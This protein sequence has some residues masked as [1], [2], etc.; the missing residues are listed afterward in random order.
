VPCCAVLSGPVGGKPCTRFLLRSPQPSAARVAPRG[1]Q[2]LHTD[3][4]GRARQ[5]AHT[6]SCRIIRGPGIALARWR[7][8]GVSCF[9]H[10]TQGTSCSPSVRSDRAAAN[11]LTAVLY[12]QLSLTGNCFAPPV[13]M[14][15]RVISEDLE[16][17]PTAPV[18]GMGSRPPSR[19]V[20]CQ[21]RT[22][23]RHSI[24]NG[25]TPTQQ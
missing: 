3:C 14:L 18:L 4:P 10:E 17:P 6:E 15:A 19:N 23:Y 1:T 7:H 13:L 8:K 12:V 22:C 5:A 20:F 24:G 11:S 2:S 9:A 21:A 25:S 16:I